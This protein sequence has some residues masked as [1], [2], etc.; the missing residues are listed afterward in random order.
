MSRNAVLLEANSIFLL[1]G[2]LESL[3]SAPAESSMSERHY[4]Y[5]YYYYDYYYH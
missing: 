3:E 2:S 1:P 4:Y 5:Y